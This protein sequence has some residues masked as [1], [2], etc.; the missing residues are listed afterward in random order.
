MEGGFC[1][2]DSRR[3]HGRCR[4][5]AGLLFKKGRA[6]AGQHLG[7]GRQ[8]VGAGRCCCWRGQVRP[9]EIISHSDYVGRL[10]CWGQAMYI[11]RTVS[12]GS[13]R[14]RPAQVVASA[15]VSRRDAATCYWPAAED[16][17][18][19]V[20]GDWTET[21]RRGWSAGRGRGEELEWL[22][23]TSTRACRRGQGQQEGTL[24]KH[25]C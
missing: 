10:V 13:Q 8:G 19:L 22:V 18:S 9:D 12:T 16:A 4:R 25:G 20:D 23:S 7:D 11:C 5:E 6:R 14:G 3:Q 1:S 24:L 2:T 15:P 21:G 17:R